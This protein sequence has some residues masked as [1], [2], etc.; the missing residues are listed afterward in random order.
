MKF[1]NIT[2]MEDGKT[3]TEPIAV[4][5]DALRAGTRVTMDKFGVRVGQT[6]VFNIPRGHSGRIM[7]VKEVSEHDYYAQETIRELQSENTGRIT[8]GIGSAPKNPLLA[9]RDDRIAQH[10]L[11][12]EEL[13]RRIREL[14]NV[15][16]EVISVSSG[17]S[18][19]SVPEVTGPLFDHIMEDVP[20]GVVIDYIPFTLY[21]TTGRVAMV[22]SGDW[23]HLN[24]E[25]RYIVILEGMTN[26]EFMEIGFIDTVLQTYN[27]QQITVIT[28]S[29]VDRDIDIDAYDTVDDPTLAVGRIPIYDSDTSTP[30]VADIVYG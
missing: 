20:D 17:S 24:T 5:G 16:P 19:V 14:E 9:R 15:A 3:I 1:Y 8:G 25:V 27:E 18:G 29:I 22:A 21:K 26:K 6:P 4:S 2:Y 7:N 12:I 28:F 30:G 13:R 11:T 23:T 10:E